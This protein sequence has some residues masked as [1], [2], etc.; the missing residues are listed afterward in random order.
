MGEEECLVFLS[1]V[2]LKTAKC[3]NVW[4]DRRRDSFRRTLRRLLDELTRLDTFSNVSQIRLVFCM[5]V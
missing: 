5:I 4:D 1:D 3:F 2:K